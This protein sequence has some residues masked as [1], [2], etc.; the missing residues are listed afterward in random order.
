[1]GTTMLK[2]VSRTALTAAA[3]VLA[4]TPMALALEAEDFGDKLVAASKVMGISFSYGSAVAEGDTVTL[5]DF[6]ITVPGEDSAEI[7]GEVVF[8]G[9]RETAGGGYTADRASIADFEYTDEDE[10]ISVSLVD[11][12]AEGITLPGT[13]TID[14]AMEIGLGLYERISAGPLSVSDSKGTELFAIDMMET[15]I[16]KPAADGSIT[17]RYSVTGIRGDLGS[18]EEAEAQEAFDAFGITQL[19]GSMS[20]MGTWW[21]QTGRATVEDVNFTIDDLGSV[22][23]NLALDGYT[24]DLYRDL[25]KTNLKMAEMADAGIELDD[26]Q[27]LAM[28]EGILASMDGLRLES[29]SLRYDDASL[30]NKVLDFIGAEQGVDGET[31]KAG[32]RFMVPMMLTEVRNAEFKGMVN[33]AVNAFISDPQNFVI[34]VEPDAPIAFAELESLEAEFDADPFALV[35]L[36]NIK[37]RANQ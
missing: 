11:I 23:L 24:E 27:M 15:V 20:G 7:P 22:S 1:M 2:T 33:D 29:G 3:L 32:L 10:G 6:S 12:A 31:F 19:S 25:I 5:S 14:S 21:P 13:L 17:S 28:S 18:I 9:V 35:D 30:F 4:G 37:I 16:D 8:E 36:L 34:S 26:D